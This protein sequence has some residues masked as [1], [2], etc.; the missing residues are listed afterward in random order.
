MS[1]K[2]LT[3]LEFRA[4]H[5][6]GMVQSVRCREENEVGFSSWYRIRDDSIKRILTVR[7]ITGC[8]IGE[9]I[10]SEHLERVV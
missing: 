2:L 4:E 8:L 6:S 9:R 3:I 1:S 10:D 5:I 7:H